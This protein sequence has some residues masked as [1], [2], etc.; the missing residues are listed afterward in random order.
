M[1]AGTLRPCCIKIKT[2]LV[3][4]G[5]VPACLSSQAGVLGAHSFTWLLAGPL[6]HGAASLGHGPGWNVT[7]GIQEDLRGHVQL[8]DCAGDGFGRP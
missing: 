4:A 3:L 6:M 8:T 1:V 7:S 2:G 5:E